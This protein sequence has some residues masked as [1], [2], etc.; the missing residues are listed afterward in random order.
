MLL[1][2]QSFASDFIVVIDP[3]HGGNDYG[4]VTQAESITHSEKDMTLLLSQEIAAE[5]KKINIKAVLTR[6]DDAN[7][8][9][10]ERTALANRLGAKL[11][12]SVHMNSNPAQSTANASGIETYI[13][14]NS[15]NESSVRLA[16]LE[17]KVLEGS[18]AE[19][20]SHS[21]VSLIVKDLILDANLKKSKNI[22]CRVQSK[23]V[24]QVSQRKKSLLDRGVKQAL[25][26]VLLGADMPSIL[27]EAGFLDHPQDR[28]R[29]E[30]ATQRQSMAKAIAE[31][32]HEYRTQSGTQIATRWLSK[33]QVH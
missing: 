20:P 8:P 15:T 22:A 27:L 3:G 33:C 7:I 9:L 24:N 5:L 18:I 14:N 30:N 25:F 12:I 2:S 32:I 11:F 21:P 29:V 16:S 6:N 26:Y 1:A 4:A 23:L 10:P 19:Q 17:N 13:L 28:H 31:A